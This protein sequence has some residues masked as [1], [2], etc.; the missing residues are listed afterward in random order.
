M[1]LASFIFGR[2]DLQF[3]LHLRFVHVTAVITAVSWFENFHFR[4]AV[5]LSDS[6]WICTC[7]IALEFQLL[8]KFILVGFHLI[9]V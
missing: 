4:T 8:L 7:L 2:F 1:T 3:I 6:C 5:G 9:D